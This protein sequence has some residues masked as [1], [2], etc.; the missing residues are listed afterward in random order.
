MLV[1][2]QILGL[3][4][5]QV[6][7]SAAFIHAPIFDEVFVAIPRG[8][9]EP[10]M[11][12]K[13]RRSLYGLKQSPINFFQHLKSN[14]Q[15]CEFRNPSP[16]TDPCLFVSSKNVCVVYVDDTLLWSPKSAWIDEAIEDLRKTGMTLEVEESVAGFLLNQVLSNALS[17]LLELK[18]SL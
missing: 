14:L 5:R 18:M 13:L 16:D 9:S 12:L 4:S 7:Y 3:S 2:S 15:K 1:L 10:G 17:Q 11:V 6:Y 8:F